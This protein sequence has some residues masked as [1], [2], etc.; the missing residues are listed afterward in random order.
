MCVSRTPPWTDLAF[1]RPEVDECAVVPV[2]S[3]KW[4]QKVAV[5]LTLT[6]K[7]KTAGKGGKTWSTLDMRRALKDKLVNYKIPQEM[8]VV[9]E[10]PRNA[11]GKGE[12]WISR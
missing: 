2:D 9:D 5:V 4:G 1:R 8:K 10:I 12:L 3:D 11:M 7:G 6:D